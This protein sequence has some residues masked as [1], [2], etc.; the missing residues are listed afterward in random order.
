MLFDSAVRQNGKK[1]LPLENLKMP[2]NKNMFFQPISDIYTL[3]M[4]LLAHSWFEIMEF[5]QVLLVIPAFWYWEI[6]ARVAK[7]VKFQ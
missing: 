2:H 5:S 6:A 3:I 7:V 4:G 1:F